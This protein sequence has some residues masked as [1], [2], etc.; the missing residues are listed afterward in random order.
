MEKDYLDDDIVIVDAARSIVGS[1]SGTLKNI[2]AAEMGGYI[3]NGILTRLE[4]RSSRF[5]REMVPMFISGLCIGSGMGQNLPRQ[6]IRLCGMDSIESAFV[7][8]EMCGSGLEAIILGMQSLRLDEYPMVLAGGV[9]AP[10]SSPFF[11]YTDELI[12]WQKM[13]VEEIQ[14][15]VV[16]ADMHDA[17]WCKMFDVHTIVHAENTTAEWVKERGM[18]PAFFKKQIDEYAMLSNERA[19]KAAARGDLK[20][21]IIIIPDSSENDELPSKL[22]PSVL[23]RRAGTQFTPDGIYLSNHNSPPL[24]GCASYLLLMKAKEARALDLL[25]MATISGYGRSGVVPRKFLLSPVSAVKKLLQKTDTVIA[26]YDLLEMNTSFGSQMLIN[27]AE[28]GLDMDKVNICGDCIAFGHPIG[29]AGSRLI[30]TLLYS[31]RRTGGKRGLASICLGGG[32]GIAM[33]IEI[34]G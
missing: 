4:K 14:T 32:N 2:S 8:N 12:A 1:L 27:R 29:A 30:T 33:G 17:L 6:I 9:E 24:A 31:L 10:S 18:E 5:S 28:L 13:S 26:D 20:E 16:K 25:P 22:K 34:R 3:V 11:I 23:A 15:K 19:L 21:E 7:V